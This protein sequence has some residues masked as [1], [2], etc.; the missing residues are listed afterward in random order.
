MGTPQDQGPTSA[1]GRDGNPDGLLAI[2]WVEL[3]EKLVTIRVGIE[4]IS[5]CEATSSCK[6]DQGIKIT[7]HFHY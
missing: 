6:R 5:I 1:I 7:F 3:D 4:G 2:G